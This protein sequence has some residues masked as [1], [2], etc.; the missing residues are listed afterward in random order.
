[1]SPIVTG[2]VIITI[3][4]SLTKVGLRDLAGG[5][6]AEDFG[7]MQN[8]LLGGGVLVSVVLISI[9][10]HKVIR[11]SAILIGLLV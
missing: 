5:V 11:S 10:N 7:S 4:L 6:G 8:L 2:C 9:V 1:M 3:G